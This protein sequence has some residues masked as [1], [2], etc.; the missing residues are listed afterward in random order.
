MYLKNFNHKRR[1]LTLFNS[2]NGMF[3]FFRLIYAGKFA[4]SRKKNK[5]SHLLI[6]VY[7]E[8]FS[9]STLFT[10]KTVFNTRF[11]D[12]CDDRVRPNR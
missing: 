3:E 8:F 4:K 7:D 2:Q 11:I 5:K 12:L 6:L 9:N 10:N 1:L